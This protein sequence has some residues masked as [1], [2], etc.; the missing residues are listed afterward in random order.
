MT[1]LPV[2]MREA[3]QAFSHILTDH[4]IDHAFIGG[5]ALNLLGSNRETLDI[6]VEVAMDNANPNELRL[7]LVQLLREAD[8]RFM[9]SD[10]KLFFFPN[11]QWDLRVPIETLARGTLG[12]PHRFSILRPGD[13]KSKCLRLAGPA[14]FPVCLFLFGLVACSWLAFRNC[15]GGRPKQRATRS[16]AYGF[17]RAF[18]RSVGR[19]VTQPVD[20]SY[21]LR[22]C[23]IS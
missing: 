14:V 2:D 7:Y 1:P 5:F 19:S 15:V 4:N 8:Q 17:V 9:I 3:A 10:L 16:V 6:D 11:E 21:K 12:L 22:L 18:F 23:P 13:G 20:Q